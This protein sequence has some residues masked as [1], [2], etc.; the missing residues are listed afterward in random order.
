LKFSRDP[1]RTLYVVLEVSQN[2]ILIFVTFIL[3]II[4]EIF[5]H[6]QELGCGQGG[7]TQKYILGLLVD[8][9]QGL[10]NFRCG[11]LQCTDRKD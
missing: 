11:N 3:V 1:S 4:L 6:T 5:I 7:D 9:R 8:I 2:E 10:Q